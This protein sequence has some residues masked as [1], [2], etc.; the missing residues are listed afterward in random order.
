MKKTAIYKIMLMLITIF[1]L[2]C[3]IQIPEAKA[4][5]FEDINNWGH[6]KFEQIKEFVTGQGDEEETT[7][8]PSGFGETISSQSGER[9][10]LNNQ[11]GYNRPR[12]SKTN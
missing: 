8:E 10:S 7:T 9:S 11:W 6:D 3:T 4:N 1:M 12:Q 2:F 5:I